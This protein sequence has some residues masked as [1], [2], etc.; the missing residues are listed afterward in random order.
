MLFQRIDTPKELFTFK[1]GSAL[2]MENKV[3]DSLE[4]L[5]E[6]SQSEELKQQFR[7]HADQ[8]RQ[9]ISNIEQSFAAIGEEA[10]DQ[11]CPSMEALQR[12]GRMNL[13]RTEDNLKDAMA[14]SA[15]DETE[16][17]EIAVYETLITQAEA[18]GQQQVVQLLRQN[19]EQEQQ[20]LDGVR[21]ASQMIAQ[22]QMTQAG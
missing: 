10:D 18:M 22:R 8:T 4:D 12:E 3:L 19:L 14:L 17:H 15:A 13:R 2:S 21:R 6:R 5:E 20:M 1:L 7:L 9:H 11:P 16:H